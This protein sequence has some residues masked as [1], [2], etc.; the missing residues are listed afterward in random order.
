[1]LSDQQNDQAWRTELLL[2]AI[3][4][5]AVLLLG[6]HT[7][8]YPF[9]R[10]HGEFAATAQVIVDGG[11]PYRD[12]WNPKPP[13]VLYLWAAI[14]TLAGP[15]MVAARWLDL[16]AALLAAVLLTN[17]GRR[18]WGTLGGVVG[19]VSYA[20]LY[21]ANLPGDLAQN[22]GF[23]TVVV[24]ISAACFWRAQRGA[25][26]IWMA[27]AGLAG[28]VA[29]AFKYPTGLWLLFLGGWL[30]LDRG[31]GVWER[32]KRLF[33]LAMGAL[34][35]WAFLLS[36]LAAQ[37]ALGG[38][39][40]SIRVTSGYTRLWVSSRLPLLVLRALFFYFVGQQFG[41]TALAMGSLFVRP[42][43]REHR[44]LYVFVLGWFGSALVAVCVQLKFYGY[45]W[46]PVLPP[47]AIL[48]GGGMLALRDLFARLLRRR[49]AGV[50]QR[51]ASWLAV[52]LVVAFLTVRVFSVPIKIGYGYRWSAPDEQT[53]LA[54]FG[55]AQDHYLTNV[56]VAHYVAAHSAPGDTLF[57]WGFEPVVY[58]L[59]DRR[60]A[61]RFIYSYPLVGEWYP[62][63]WRQE[64]VDQLRSSP[65]AFVLVLENDALPWVTG[66]ETDSATQLQDF[67]ELLQLIEESY[68][69]DRQI[70]SFQVY[71]Y[72]PPG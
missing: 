15:T 48:M 40:E 72:R 55:A 47:L 71:R 25:R 31:V 45:H 22:D 23:M 52:G 10:D 67:P 19:G 8:A 42:R 61:T 63:A 13:A 37:Q 6:L 30:L 54:R 68:A 53:Y 51:A 60:P 33:F 65:P 38:F 24:V 70:G 59:S 35:V 46:L 18:L 44:S 36:Y 1:L 2:L 7:L 39:L 16:L 62:A 56:E 41:A 69:P 64:V 27:A 26:S 5:L 66:I 57:I 32:L 21:L 58:A 4:S 3:V 14:L 11:V 43:A 17:L 49:E 50:R 20:A 34:V 9:R 28:G 12:V 29:V